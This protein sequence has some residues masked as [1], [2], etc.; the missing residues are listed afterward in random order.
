MPKLHA[1]TALVVL[2]ATAF[3]LAAAAPA[4]A[5]PV[6]SRSA[7]DQS[8]A[9][10]EADLATLQEVVAQDQVAAALEARGFSQDEVNQRLAQLAPD[11]L[12]QLTGQ[13]DQLQAAGQVPSY[14]W[15]LI[16]VLIIV[17]IASAI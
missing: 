6:P 15:I 9:E 2:V 14:I 7:D 12:Q 4:P 11:E 8:L 5:L 17:V 13:I 1:K 16:A 3:I 10:R